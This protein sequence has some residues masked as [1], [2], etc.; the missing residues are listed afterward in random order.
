MDSNSV[1]PGRTPKPPDLPAADADFWL[2]SDG[3]L[4]DPRLIDAAI[5]LWPQMNAYTKRRLRDGGAAL[6]AAWKVLQATSKVIRNGRR[7]AVKDIPNYLFSAFIHEVNGLAT[8]DL[9]VGQSDEEEFHSQPVDDNLESQ[10]LGWLEAQR[11]LRSLDDYERNLI[12]MKIDQGYSWK[13]IGQ[14]L[15]VS[16]KSARVQYCQTLQAIRK[17]FRKL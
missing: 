14:L 8:Q 6:G 12:V 4:L 13:E 15:G 7:D 16:H 1:S 5:S 11:I 17:R 3:R 9:A 10:I 2:D